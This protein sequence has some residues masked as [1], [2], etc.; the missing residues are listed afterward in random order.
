MHLHRLASLPVQAP[1][2]AVGIVL[3]NLLRNACN[4]SRHGPI[5]VTVLETSIT[6][7]DSG[8]GIPEQEIDNALAGHYRARGASR[9]GKGL[10][11]A[12]V[13]RVCERYGWQVQLANRQPHGL[14]ATVSFVK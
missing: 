8:P 3:G 5:S 7:A 13:Q 12:I 6:I 14:I 4:Y 11:L 1:S 2:P 9:A 10:G